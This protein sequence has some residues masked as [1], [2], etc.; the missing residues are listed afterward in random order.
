MI[1]QPLA[2]ELTNFEKVLNLADELG[3]SL[4]ALS[5]LIRR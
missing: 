3:S 5:L 4:N 1:L 2:S